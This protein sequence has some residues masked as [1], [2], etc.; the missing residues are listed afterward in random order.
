MPQEYKDW[1]EIPM[2]QPQSHVQTI[3][4]FIQEES[5]F[6]THEEAVKGF[7]RLLIEAGVKADWSWERRLCEQLSTVLY[8]ERPSLY[9]KSANL[10]ER[11]NLYLKSAN[12]SER[13]SLYLKSANLSERSNLYLKSANL[14]ER[15]NLYL[16]N[17]KSITNS[18]RS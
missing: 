1:L 14:S 5:K 13:S 16:K 8:I 4:L 11:S 6:A 17:D 3:T 10:S 15:S 18:L 7:K 9:L 12:L 2:T